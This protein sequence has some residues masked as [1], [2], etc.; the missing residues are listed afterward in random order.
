[1][2]LTTIV[3]FSFFFGNVAR[4]PVTQAPELTFFS[5]LGVPTNELG[6]HSL[7]KEMFFEINKAYGAQFKDI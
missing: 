5:R 3:V 1:V 2:A 7:K 6:L 4:N